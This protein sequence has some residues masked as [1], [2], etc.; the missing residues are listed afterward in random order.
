[1]GNSLTRGAL[2]L[3]TTQ[4][5]KSLNFLIKGNQSNLQIYNPDNRTFLPDYTTANMLLVPQLYIAGTPD[6]QIMQGRLKTAPIWLVDGKPATASAVAT[7]KPYALTVNTNTDT[8]SKYIE[9]TA[10]YVDPDTLLE[11]TVKSVYMINKIISVG[12]NLTGTILLPKGDTIDQQTPSIDLLAQLQRG[13]RVDT[14]NVTYDWYKLKGTDWVKLTG[15]NESI[16]AG[17]NTSRLIVPAAAVTNFETFKCIMTDTDPKS[18]STGVTVE[19]YQTVVDRTD[20]YEIQF[21]TPQG[22][23]LVNGQGS[24]N[25][26][27]QIWQGINMLPNATTEAKFNFAWTKIDKDGVVDP[28]WTKAGRVISVSNADF[29]IKSS[30]IC[31]VNTK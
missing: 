24:L 18:G 30:F 25:V 4:D 28:K 8:D 21:L 10:I 19:I 7:T 23:V 11:S 29:R 26:E 2:T 20:P 27:A 14:D 5:A 15:S 13:T 17:Y 16:T 12:G 6:E 3:Y 1:M 22:T 9:C 31:D